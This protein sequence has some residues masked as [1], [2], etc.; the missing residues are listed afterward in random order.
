MIIKGEEGMENKP[1]RWG[2]SHY[3]ISGS[4]QRGV[5]EVMSIENGTSG[6]V[7]QR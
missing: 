1:K 2:K 6:R 5:S 4:Y 7:D 3:V